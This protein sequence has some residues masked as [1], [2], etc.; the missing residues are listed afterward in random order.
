MASKSGYQHRTVHTGVLDIHVAE[1]PGGQRPLIMLHGIGMDWRVWQGVSRRLRPHFH[2][3]LLDLRGHGESEKPR[4]GYTLAHYAA[5]VEDVIDSLG[6]SGVGL[7]GSSLGG[8]VAAAVEAPVDIVSRRVLVD[9]PITGGPIRDPEEFRTILR[10]KYRPKSELANYL[11]QTNPTLSPHLAGVMSEMWHA[12]ADGVI[13]EPLDDPESYFDIDGALAAI[14]SPTLLLRADPQMH[15]ALTV[16]GAERALRL[17]P[18]A[19]E[20]VVHGA[21]HAIHGDKPDEFAHIVTAFMRS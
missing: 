12:T 18:H 8:M 15:P 3:F 21:S 19:E 13:I 9:P 14:P 7:V 4:R 6:L 1:A 20:R 10:L 2:L 17:L 16:T 5:D 11:R